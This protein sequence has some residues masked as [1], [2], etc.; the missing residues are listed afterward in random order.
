MNNL[1]ETGIDELHGLTE[2]EL[3]IFF[4]FNRMIG[5]LIHCHTN[6]KSGAVSISDLVDIV[7][8]KMER[9]KLTEEEAT[10][11]ATICSP[12]ISHF[13]WGRIEQGDC[14]YQYGIIFTVRVMTYRDTCGDGSG[15]DCPIIFSFRYQWNKTTNFETK[16]AVEENPDEHCKMSRVK[17]P[18]PLVQIDALYDK[19]NDKYWDFKNEQERRMWEEIKAEKDDELGGFFDGLKG[20]G[21]ENNEN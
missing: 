20:D 13:G 1:I 2:D 17:N 16:I 11:I 8:Y 19:F 4:K 6:D 3:Y 5:Y 12:Y 9:F 18:I 21:N 10:R 14:E 7:K 15:I